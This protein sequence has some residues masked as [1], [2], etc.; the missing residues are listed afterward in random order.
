[1]AK[2][3]FCDVCGGEMTYQAIPVIFLGNDVHRTEVYFRDPHLDKFA[4]VQINF[5]F[6]RS[7]DDHTDVCGGCRHDI[8]M[9]ALTESVAKPV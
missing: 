5:F 7:E 3:I 6:P 8:L 9:K 2:K 4:E 1:M